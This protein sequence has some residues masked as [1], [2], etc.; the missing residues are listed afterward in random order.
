[1]SGRYLIQRTSQD[2]EYVT[3][4]I[5]VHSYSSRKCDAT[6]F[7]SKFHAMERINKR[8]PKS[9]EYKDARTIFEREW[10]TYRFTA[11]KE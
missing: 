5:D 9:G 7:T 2:G 6:L 11:I 8:A 4:Y 3:Y 10:P 1:M